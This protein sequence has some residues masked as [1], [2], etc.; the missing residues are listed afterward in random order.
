MDAFRHQDIPFEKVVEAVAPNRNPDT[1]PLVQV[2]FAVQNAASPAGTL[3]EMEVHPFQGDTMYVRADLEV[4][5]YEYG[6]GVI[7]RWLYN[8]DLF[9]H[10]RIVQMADH[11]ERIVGVMTAEL[12]SADVS[13]S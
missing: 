2:V 7:L 1:L 12:S 13:I 5:A 3:G 10:W 9:D 11:F 4:H 8:T 6:D